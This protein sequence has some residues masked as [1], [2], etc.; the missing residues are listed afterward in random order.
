M[1]CNMGKNAKTQS[2]FKTVYRGYERA[3]VDEFIA[4]EL[5]KSDSVSREQ[6]EKICELKSRCDAMEC[7]LKSLRSREEKIKDALLTATE[8][9]DRMTADIKVRYAMELERLKLFRAKWN[10]AYEE[11]KERYHFSKDALNMES[12]AVAAQ[13]EIQKF[14][15][16]DFS[17]SKGDGEDEFEKYFKAESERLAPSASGVNELKEKLR[18]VEDKKQTDRTVAKTEA[19]GGAT[20]AAESAFS[21][22]D[23][24]S[25]KESLEDICRYLGLKK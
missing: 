16:Q 9:A 1:R 15:A 17:L 6:K 21:I 11:L 14:L 19:V 24:V 22:E 5:L 4:Q 13:M 8:N 12:V 18:A 25:P 23:A 10:G 20:V 3:A 2:R 7:E